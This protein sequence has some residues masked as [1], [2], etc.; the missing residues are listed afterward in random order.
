MH[1]ANFRSF[2]K[3][4]FQQFHSTSAQSADV[5]NVNQINLILLSKSL[6]RQKPAKIFHLCG[7]R[8]VKMENSEDFNDYYSDLEMLNATPTTMDPCSSCTSR[9]SN[10]HYIQSA[11]QVKVPLLIKTKSR[12]SGVCMVIKFEFVELNLYFVLITCL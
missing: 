10:R 12:H 4:N 5:Y 11:R 9:T 7:N 1:C 3:K 8:V 2:H 6:F